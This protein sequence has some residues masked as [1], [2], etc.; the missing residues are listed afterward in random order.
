MTVSP[1]ATGVL[2]SQFTSLSQPSSDG[3]PLPLP[4][5]FI[6]IQPNWTDRWSA[7]GGAGSCLRGRNVL[8]CTFSRLVMPDG[9]CGKIRRPGKSAGKG[10]R[11]WAVQSCSPRSPAR[12]RA[13]CPLHTGSS[14]CPSFREPSVSPRGA[15]HTH[16]HT[17][18]QR[19]CLMTTGT[20]VSPPTRSQSWPGRAGSC[21]AQAQPPAAL[22]ESAASPVQFDRYFLRAVERGRARRLTA[23]PS[24]AQRHG[25]GRADLACIVRCRDSAHRHVRCDRYL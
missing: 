24:A 17:H 13:S 25:W 14:V 12:G 3:P 21:K 8:T 6:A 20:H 18:T 15:H 5:P 4:Q 1:T 2:L 19:G 22:R 7:A 11:R 9:R 23:L 10:R 16:T